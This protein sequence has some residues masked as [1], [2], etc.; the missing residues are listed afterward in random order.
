M[1]YAFDFEAVQRK[2]HV[3]NRPKSVRCPSAQLAIMGS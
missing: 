2:A 3:F 1:T